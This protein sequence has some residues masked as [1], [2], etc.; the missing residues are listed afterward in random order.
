V[1]VISHCGRGRVGCGWHAIACPIRDRCEA[2]SEAAAVAAAN[3][4]MCVIAVSAQ[5]I[6]WIFK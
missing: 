4:S 2:H 6:G 5:G 1:L 3:E